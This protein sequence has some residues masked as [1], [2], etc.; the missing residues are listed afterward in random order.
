MASCKLIIADKEVSTELSK[1]TREDIYGNISTRV[2]GPNDEV[3][4]KAGIPEDGK[5]FLTRADLKYAP[6]VGEDY[7]LKPSKTVNALTGEAMEQIASSFSSPPSFRIATTD[8][9]SLLEVSA[10]YL[11]HFLREKNT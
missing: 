8:E 4:S 7:T 10:V 3:L 9:V 11:W 5:L 6:T 2:L 1:I